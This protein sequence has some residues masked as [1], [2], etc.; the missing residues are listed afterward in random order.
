[1]W[2]SARA[3]RSAFY[4]TS[5]QPL[6]KEEAYKQMIQQMKVQSAPAFI[7]KLLLQRWHSRGI[8]ECLQ[9]VAGNV[10]RMYRRNARAIR[11]NARHRL[12]I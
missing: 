8:D 6:F 10:C 3:C 7:Q 2:V 11:S 1:M 4:K 5:T 9:H 12:F